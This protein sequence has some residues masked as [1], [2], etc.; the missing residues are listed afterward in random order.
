MAERFTTE[1]LEAMIDSK[2]AELDA[3]EV[4]EDAESIIVRGVIVKIH[5]VGED[6]CVVDIE[7]L[8]EKEIVKEV[9]LELERMNE[10]MRGFL[11]KLPDYLG[12]TK[13]TF[14]A[15]K[16]LQTPKTWNII[17]IIDIDASER[18]KEYYSDFS[19]DISNRLQGALAL[20]S[21]EQ[22]EAINTLKKEDLTAKDVQ[23]ALQLSTG[24]EYIALMAPFISFLSSEE[25]DILKKATSS[26]L[27]VT[28]RSDKDSY[29]K[30]V[31][32]W[33]EYLFRL[34]PQ[35]NR[36]ASVYEFYQ[37][38]DRK[39]VGQEQIKKQMMVEYLTYVNTVGNKNKS[40][41]FN[42]AITGTDGSGKSFIASA[43]SE[44]LA[45]CCGINTGNI[46]VSA[47][48]SDIEQ[49]CG[50]SK[51]YDNSSI[52]DLAEKL[53]NLQY[54][55]LVLEGLDECDKRV[56]T[57]IKNLLDGKLYNNLFCNYI[58]TDNLLII[59]SLADSGNVPN[60]I[61]KT[62]SS[63]LSVEPYSIEEIMTIGKRTICEMEEQLASKRQ[64]RIP[65]DVMRHIYEAYC[66][67]DDIKGFRNRLQKAYKNAYC[68]M[69]LRNQKQISV[70]ITNL[71]EFLSVATSS[72]KDEYAK[73]YLLLEQKYLQ[74][75]S[76]NYS[77][78]IQK[79]IEE[80]RLVY[81]NDQ[82][83][84]RKDYALKVLTMLVNPVKRSIRLEPERIMQKLNN[85]HYG[86]DEAKQKL[87]GKMMSAYITH[88]K[89]RPLLFAGPA[90]VGK[91]SLVRSVANAAGIP[92]VKISLN[93]ISTAEEI[94]GYPR[95]YNDAKAGIIL[96]AIS[97]PHTFSTTA[98]LLMDEIDKMSLT[99]LNSLFGILDT[100]SNSYYDKY[101]EAEIPMDGIVIVATA[102][103]LDRMPPA[104]IDRFDLVKIKGYSAKEKRTV[105][106]EYILPGLNR[107]YGTSIVL[108]DAC[109]DKIISVSSG[110]GMRDTEKI[111]ENLLEH[112]IVREKS[113]SQKTEMTLQNLE[114]YISLSHDPQTQ[115]GFRC[116]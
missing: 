42:I 32:F 93:G 24:P 27:L 48:S 89:V 10:D 40:A 80:L 67:R 54:G 78:D 110:E 86:I 26:Y 108:N 85:S 76:E 84:M 63:T 112:Y 61:R 36:C 107:K 98:V 69:L 72:L 102:N 20:L 19:E 4:D 22:K 70:T 47:Y 8:Q 71:G 5:D 31:N 16:H 35:K 59:A 56:Y 49:L 111:M 82:D 96:K 103:D 12:R 1:M 55:A 75:K 9:R 109:V 95:S 97:T 43:I 51:I 6:Y 52:G 64:V 3:L 68:G 14:S 39:I 94:C 2:I 88:H 100:E 116:G 73:T 18:V 91:T 60:G 114:T 74:L 28:V 37:T 79:R 115:F 13:L 46:D 33:G 83:D 62:F 66:Y 11:D 53:R 34:P 65:E 57:P 23:N 87:I 105:L 29:R 99:A 106:T 58:N 50:T 38:L 44:S 81:K 92:F 90:G 41:G 113:Y 30:I 7:E 104:L 15:V 25:R 21:P 45:E 101:A 77:P 17:K